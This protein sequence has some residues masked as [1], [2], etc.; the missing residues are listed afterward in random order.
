MNTLY[1]VFAATCVLEVLLILI[2]TLLPRLGGV[3]KD[4]IETCRKAPILDVILLVIIWVPWVGGALLAGWL[5]VLT[6]LLGQISVMQLWIFFHELAHSKEAKTPRI[7]RF[8]TQRFGWWRH[9]LALWA[10]ALSLPVFFV[11]RFAEVFIYPLLVWLLEFPAYDNSEWVTVS[12]QKFEGLVGHD[13]IWCLYCDWMTGVYSLGA[14]MLRN[15]E[16]F[17]CPIRF[18]DG[19]KCENCKIDFPDLEN[20]WV[21]ID[22][23]MNDVEEV[24]KEKYNGPYRSWY[25]HPERK[26]DK[27]V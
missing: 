12:R 8:L 3:G 19:K 25:G 22:G 20:G 9:Y 2:L 26:Q 17:W 13:L 27:P 21:A 1:T 4:I 7:S 10:T 5:G 24:L 18:Y 6:S 23:T 14:E 16:S 11:I 15:V